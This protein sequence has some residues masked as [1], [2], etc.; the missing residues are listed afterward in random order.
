M[1]GID[2]DTEKEGNTFVHTKRVTGR[3]TL[4][5]KEAKE[6]EKDREPGRKQTHTE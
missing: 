3:K 2:I 1:N 5:K 4:Q 6:K